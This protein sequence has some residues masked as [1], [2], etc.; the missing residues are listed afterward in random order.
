[1]KLIYK[2]TNWQKYNQNSVAIDFIR[3]NK[4]SVG[5]SSFHS[6]ASSVYSSFMSY[7]SGHV[8][9][10]VSVPQVNVSLCRTVLFDNPILESNNIRPVYTDSWEYVQHLSVHYL[11]V[12]D[13]LL[14]RLLL[15]FVVV[16]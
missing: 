4:Y 16:K 14:V 13:T 15:C 9:K 1:M 7:T 2:W 10:Q 11:T 5:N 8:R 12:E 3:L 6:I